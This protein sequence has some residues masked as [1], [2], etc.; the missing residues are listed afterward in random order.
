MFVVENGMQVKLTE[1]PLKEASTVEYVEE[2]KF[3]TPPTPLNPQ[4]TTKPIDQR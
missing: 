1:A 4:G 3:P 2:G